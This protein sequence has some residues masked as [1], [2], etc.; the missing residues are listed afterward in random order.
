M[1]V[2]SNRGH[3]S[4]EH[5]SILRSDS[6]QRTAYNDVLNGIN[7][8]FSFNNELR[9]FEFEHVRYVFDYRT[10][11]FIRIWNLDESLT[12]NELIQCA[13][14]GITDDQRSELYEL[15]RI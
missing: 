10:E 13:H 1:T 12:T 5:V 8:R 7:G 15:C 4:T 9:L 3:S 11:Q 6:P 2:S 14:D